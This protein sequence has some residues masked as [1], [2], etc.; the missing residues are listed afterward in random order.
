MMA[1]LLIT[2]QSMVPPAERRALVDLYHATGGA[3]W[4]N[5]TG[6]LIGD[7]CAV[8]WFGV[9]CNKEGTHVTMVF[10]N[11]EYSGNTLVGTLPESFYNLTKLEH[12][13]LSNDRPGWSRLTGQLLPA[14]GRMQGLKCLYLSHA[15]DMSGS[16]PAAISTLTRLQGLYL[17]WTSFS[18]PLPDLRPLTNLSKLFLD[19][20]PLGACPPFCKNAFNGT[21]RQLVGLPLA[22]LDVAGNQFSGV[23]PTELCAIPKCTAWGNHFEAPARPK[24]CCDGVDTKANDLGRMALAGN[25]CVDHHFP[26]PGSTFG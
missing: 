22:H 4:K 24:G 9:F 18:G 15:G 21:L 6:W 3:Q 13:Y 26:A 12:I 25:E 20:A 19:A 16:L 7:P 14:I 8:Y 2:V 23:F 11:P 1:L 5:S 10:P 17:R